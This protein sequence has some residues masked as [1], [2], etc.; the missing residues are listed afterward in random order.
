[1]IYFATGNDPALFTALNQRDDLGIIT[2]PNAG[3]DVAKYP[4]CA[5]IADNGCFG[6]NWDANR[7]YRWLER[8]VADHGRRVLWAVCPDVV[9]NHDATFDRWATWAPVIRDLG[10]EPAFV[11]QNGC[12]SIDVVPEDARVLF[13]GGDDTYKLGPQAAEIARIAAAQSRWVHMGRV[14]SMKRMAYAAGLG[15]HSVDGTFISFGPKVNLPI[16]CGWLNR[17]HEPQLAL[18]T[19]RTA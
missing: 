19:R 17:V 11:L 7:W 5:L 15:C 6:G 9:S 12:D 4:P 16:V 8:L 2:T 3:N 14:S 13:I 18:T 1:M 10:A